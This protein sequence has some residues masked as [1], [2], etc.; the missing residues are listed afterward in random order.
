[1]I[2]DKI[3][4]LIA[5]FQSFSDWEARYKHL[6]DLGKKMPPMDEKNRI[7]IRLVKFNLRN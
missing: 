3:N 7:P 2:T 6:I 5:E 4:A 1:M